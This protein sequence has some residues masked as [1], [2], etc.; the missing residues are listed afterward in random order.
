MIKLLILVRRNPALSHEQFR[1]HLSQVH[2]PLVRACPATKSYVRKYVQSYRLGDATGPADPDGAAELWFD[3]R[4]D[5]DRFFSDPHYLE[6]VRPDEPRF[7]DLE[8]SIF[9]VTEEAQIV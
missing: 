8:N 7:A 6:V 1:H 2:A 9:M 3:S 5:M 4:D